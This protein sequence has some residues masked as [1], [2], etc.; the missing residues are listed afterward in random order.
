MVESHPHTIGDSAYV[1]RI[2]ERLSGPAYAILGYQTLVVEEAAEAGI[3]A[4]IDDLRKVL[5]A[6]GHLTRLIEDLLA[7]DTPLPAGEDA[8]A[9]LRHDL[10]TPLNAILGYSEMVV[11]EFAEDLSPR[12]V[13]EIA[14]VVHES[15]VL[16]ASIDAIVGTLTSDTEDAASDTVDHSIADHLARTIAAPILRQESEHGRILIVDD[17]SSNRD[18]LARRLA[19][20][21]HTV[22]TVTCA[23]EAID[24][25]GREAFDLALLDILMPG[26]NGIEL[27]AYMKSD[28]VLRDIPVLMMSGLR[29]D[30]AVARCI[31]AGAED[32]LPK[33]VEPVLL[34]ARISACL[35]RQ[36]LRERERCYLRR[37]ED[38]RRR[39][40][41]LLH[42]ILPS[43][44]VSRLDT[45]EAVIAD[46]FDDATIIFADI[47]NF[48]S[49]AAAIPPAI[50]IK[51]LGA[52]FTR[53]DDLAIQH[54]VE[55][56]KT[57]GDAYMAASGIPEPR[58]DHAGAAIGFARAI[59]RELPRLEEGR[60]LELRIGIG[61]GPIV[62]GLIGRKRFI[63]DV[64]GHT[65]NLASRLEASGVPGR[66]HISRETMEAL[67]GTGRAEP[68]GVLDL[69]GIGLV[70]TYLVDD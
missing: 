11:E 7:P 47:V 33:P 21:G 42:D 62:A 49:F 40:T 64:W 39:A 10:R 48:T 45:G 16:L 46:R 23:A 43:Q 1:A 54:G 12:L 27:L 65:V 22:T 36:R 17:T 19:R 30:N 9:R 70:P 57:I 18:L 61:S 56:I 60:G 59:I 35:E 37:I 2:A 32:Y 34:R 68:R 24:A 15:R 4:A 51:R 38:E 67:G 53:F 28:P 31:E 52:V 5:A 44:V 55:K 14:I 25:M 3:D 66:I 29:E 8:E 50:L 20:E 58:K 13:E 63:Y 6:A 26:M 41:A 69:K